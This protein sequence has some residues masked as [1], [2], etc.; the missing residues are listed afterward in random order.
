MNHTTRITTSVM[1]ALAGLSGIEHGIGEILQGNRAPAGMVIESWPDSAWFEI[2]AGE[3]AMTILPNLRT[4][5]VLAALFSLIFLSWATLLVHRPHA[6][7][8]LITLS[9]IMLLFGAGFGPPL[10]GVIVG[11]TATRIHAPLTWWR[12]RLSSGA[13][14]VLAMLWPW[15]FAACLTVWLYLLLGLILVAGWFGVNEPIL[16]S[17]AAA[18]FLAFGLLL[19]TIVCAFARDLLRQRV[20][21]QLPAQA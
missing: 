19:L 4:T 17:V 2:L 14:A 13:Q 21:Y 16:L 1:G 9:I 6:G 7:L 11:S 3:P 5:G 8:V 12:A 15:A 10:L 18:V 20:A